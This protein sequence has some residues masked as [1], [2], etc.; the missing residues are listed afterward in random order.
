MTS[1]KTKYY[2]CVG[3]GLCAFDHL[4]LIDKYPHAD[5]KVSAIEYSRQGGGPVATGMA[6]LGK[7]GSDVAFVGRV[8]DDDEGG[9][10]IRALEGMGVDASR[11]EVR[12]GEKTALAFCWVENGTGRRAIVLSMEALK[13]MT[14]RDVRAD[15]FPRGR[16]LLMDGRDIEACL[17]AA[18]LTRRWG[19]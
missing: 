4:C 5:E 3:I 19:G 12:R 7:L 9:F 8:G 15:T 10:V 13:P 2:D 14:A 16:F 1:E 11:V 6:T 17:K 18:R